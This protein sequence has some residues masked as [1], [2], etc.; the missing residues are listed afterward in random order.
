MAKKYDTEVLIDLVYNEMKVRFGFMY[1]DELSLLKKVKDFSFEVDGDNLVEVANNL[2]YKLESYYLQ[3]I[4][5]KV[6]VQDYFY[7]NSYIRSNIIV[8]DDLKENIEDIRNLVNFLEK[9][10]ISFRDEEII[11]YLIFENSNLNKCLEKIV[12]CKTKGDLKSLGCDSRVL[13]LLDF[14]CLSYDIEMID[15]I[16]FKSDNLKEI[17]YQDDDLKLYLNSISGTSLFTLEEEVKY[18]KEYKT[19]GNKEILNKIIESNLRLVVYV[20]KRYYDKSV[21]LSFLDLIQ[22][23]NI[24]LMKAVDKF[25]VDKGYKFSTY[26]VWWIRQEIIRAIKKNGKFIRIPFYQEEKINK[27]LKLKEN[28]FYQKGR[29]GNYN[30]LAEYSGKS[31]EEIIN[32]EKMLL[33]VPLSLNIP[34]KDNEGNEEILEQFIESEIYISPESSCFKSDLKEKMFDI[35]QSLPE[36]ERKIIMLRFGFENGNIYTLEEV[37]KILGISRERVRQI[38]ER[39]LKELGRPSRVKKIKDY[40]YY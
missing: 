2:F 26:A 11:G 21:S 24:G 3:C 7:V 33:L 19:S 5:E 37:G 38:E 12:S 34:L 9:V 30:E 15:E 31:L 32:M 35:L 40:Y 39:G 28:F 36:R 22:E 23:G 27:Y 16:D 18:F 10:D 25:D 4:K 20:A 13:E 29:Y 14:Y 8:K 1:I 17:E 6:E